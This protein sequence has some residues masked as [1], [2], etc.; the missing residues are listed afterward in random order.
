VSKSKRRS[1]AKSRRPERQ[2]RREPKELKPMNYRTIRRPINIEPRTDGQAEYIDCIDNN[3]IVICNGLAGTGKTLIAVGHALRL[4]HEHPLKYKRLIMVRPYIHA[5]GE[6]MGYLPGDIDEKMKPFVAPM[7]DSLDYF[8]NKGEIQGLV[9]SGTIEVIPIAYMRGRTFNNSIIIFDEAQNSRWNHMKMF[10]TRIGFNTKAII[11]G[12]V[13]QSDLDEDVRGDNGL[14]VSAEKLEGV[15]GIGVVNLTQQ[16]VVRS[17][18][19]RRILDK[20]E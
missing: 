13:S 4:M 16:D 14:L 3:E 20:L 7:F 9:D 8:L 15:R 19:V 17:P 12:D 1:Q 5:Q 2:D 10:L 18:I 11:E 6:D